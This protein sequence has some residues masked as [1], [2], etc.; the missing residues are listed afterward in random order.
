[1]IFHEALY[2]DGIIMREWIVKNPAATAEY[3][4]DPEILRPLIKSEIAALKKPSFQYPDRALHFS[5]MKDK[6][7][8]L[9]ALQKFVAHGGEGIPDLFLRA[10]PECVKSDFRCSNLTRKLVLP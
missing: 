9:D 5:I 6:K 3:T 2:P 7:L 10:C 8:W 1:M 4:A